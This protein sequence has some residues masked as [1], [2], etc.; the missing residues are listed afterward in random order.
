[1]EEILNYLNNYFYSYALITNV[2]FEEDG[3]S[4]TV[5]KF[6]NNLYKG[7]YIKIEE[8][9]INDGIF[10]IISIKDN[11]DNITITT[12][13]VD[14]VE[15][16]FRCLI[17]VLAVPRPVIKLKEAIEEFKAKNKPSV[18]TSES[19]GNYSRSWAT[20]SKGAI[21]TWKDVFKED[22]NQY[23]CMFDNR[24]G[25]EVITWL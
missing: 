23:R 19:F 11:G 3:K 7:Q 13:S 4:F 10:K 12:D 14:F 21:L 6:K 24:E 20:N 2:T 1:M 18:Y 22:L 8:T 16:E 25:I 17:L 5:S 15:G 9:T